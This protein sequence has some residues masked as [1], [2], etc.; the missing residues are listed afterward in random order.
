MDTHPNEAGQTNTLANAAAF[1]LQAKGEA[2]KIKHIHRLDRDTTGAVLFA[3]HSLAGSILDR[4]LEERLIK[5]TYLAI[6]E[7]FFKNN[8]VSLIFLSAGT[9]IT[10]QGEESLPQ[11]RQ[12][13]QSITLYTS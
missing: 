2:V 8:P 12:R 7:G 6:T 3:K 13:S 10:R 1:Y 5:R 4:M 9:A 11:D